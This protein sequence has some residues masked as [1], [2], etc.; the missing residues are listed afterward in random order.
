VTD[1]ILKLP[2]I[3]TFVAAVFGFILLRHWLFKRRALYLAWWSAGVFIYGA[4]TLIESLTSLFGWHEVLFRAWYIVGALLGAGPLAQGT[5]YLLLRRRTAH[6][7][8]VILIAYAALAALF[9]LLTPLDYDQVE[10]RRLSGD[11]I[12]WQWVRAF[13]PLINMYALVFLVGGAAL[14][15]WKYRV[16]SGTASRCWGNVLIAAGA[17][18]PAIGGT[19]TRLG[20]TEWLYVTELIGILMIWVGYTFIKRD[21]GKSIHANQSE[22]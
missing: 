3:T 12:Q 17:L 6:R 18:L 4:G 15:A 7:L 10:G 5:V 1:L 19:M 8:S 22:E 11:V 9:V 20:H 2:I 13:S 21:M 14:S 16:Q